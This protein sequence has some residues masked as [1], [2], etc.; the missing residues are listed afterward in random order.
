[1]YLERL[2]FSG[3][4]ERISNLQTRGLNRILDAGR[5]ARMIGNETLNGSDVYALS[6]MFY[7]L[8]KGIWAELYSGKTIDTIGEN[9]QRAHINR[10][11]FLPNDAKNQLGRKMLVIGNRAW[12]KLI[13]RILRLWLEVS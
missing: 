1:M 7:D 10:L 9:L 12:F 8:R 2:A 6:T 3:H 11:N 4:I 13:N 5:M